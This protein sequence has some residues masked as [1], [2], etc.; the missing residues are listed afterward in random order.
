MNFGMRRTF[1]HRKFREVLYLVSL[2]SVLLY[3]E[4]SFP[5]IP[6]ITDD[7]GTQG[8]GNFQLELFAEYGQAGEATIT[9]TMSAL[10]A[11]L[12]Y[13]VIDTVD[14]ILGIPYQAW[15]A[16]NSGA[17]SVVKGN[18]LAVLALEAKW[19]FYEKEGLSFALKPG[20]TIPNGR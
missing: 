4:S 6:L 14:I 18:G 20:F 13:G 12:T 9:T 16:N 1:I 10:S 15:S 7:T 11:M 8:E 3:A 17:E 2:L 5:A 19:R